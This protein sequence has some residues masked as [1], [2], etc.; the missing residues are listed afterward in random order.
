MKYFP[1]ASIFVGGADNVILLADDTVPTLSAAAINAAGTKLTLTFSE[2]VRRSLALTL[3]ATLGN[4]TLGAAQLDTSN[5]DINKLV[6]NLSRTLLSGETVTLT[7]A[8]GAVI[9]TANNPLVAQV[10]SAVTNSSTQTTT[11]TTTT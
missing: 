10:A 8:S 11:T 6:F 7:S 1:A 5:T 3:T 4:F 9:D 2:P